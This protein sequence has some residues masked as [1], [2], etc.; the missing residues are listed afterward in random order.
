MSRLLV[1][2][3][4]VEKRQFA[5]STTLAELRQME[6]MARSQ[7]PLTSLGTSL[8]LTLEEFRSRLVLL[9]EERLDGLRMSGEEDCPLAHQLV[10]VGF[11]YGYGM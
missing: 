3:P 9:L 4:Q 8:L 7:L 1:L 10:Q 2:M 5:D 6:T 11:C